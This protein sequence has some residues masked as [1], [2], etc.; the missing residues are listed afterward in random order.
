[1]NGSNNGC[2]HVAN[3]MRESEKTVANTAPQQTPNTLESLHKIRG[4]L[5]DR[6]RLVDQTIHEVERSRGGVEAIERYQA[7][8]ERMMREWRTHSFNPLVCT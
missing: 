1:M 6:L 5:V 8:S 3:A 7:Q 2:G 4:M